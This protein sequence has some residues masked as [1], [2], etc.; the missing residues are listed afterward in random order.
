M[1]TKENLIKELARLYIGIT[2]SEFTRRFGCYD[3]DRLARHLRL[4]KVIY[5]QTGALI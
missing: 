1:E 3:K 5:L 4:A 2:V